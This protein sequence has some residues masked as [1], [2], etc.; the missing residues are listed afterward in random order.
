[1]SDGWVWL[2]CLGCG[3]PVRLVAYSGGDWGLWSDELS[4]FIE[5]HTSER[6]HPK[7]F[8][9]IDAS[10]EG[11]SFFEIVNEKDA[12]ME[13]LAVNEFIRDPERLA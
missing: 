9:D 6:C 13:T 10:R 12:P 11:Y 7:A 4:T 1:M 8:Y 5:K 2:R 3:T